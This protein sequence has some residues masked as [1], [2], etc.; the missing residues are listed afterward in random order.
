MIKKATKKRGRGRPATGN[1]FPIQKHVF[2][3]EEHAATLKRLA[4]AAGLSE[5]AYVR[6]LIKLA[7]VK[8]H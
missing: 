7:D 8:P 4:A 2:L 3:D 1:Q 6:T 5:S